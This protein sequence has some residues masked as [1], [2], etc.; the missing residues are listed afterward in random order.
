MKMKF[1]V[2]ENLKSYSLL[3][4]LRNVIRSDT[5]TVKYVYRSFLYHW[6][7]KL[8][9]SR[10]DFNLKRFK[11]DKEQKKFYKRWYYLPKYLNHGMYSSMDDL[12][13]LH[14]SILEERIIL[15][16][17]IDFFYIH[18]NNF[19][20][21]GETLD[22]TPPILRF[23]ETISNSSSFHNSFS[24]LEII[25]EQNEKINYEKNSVSVVFAGLLGWK[26]VS[27]ESFAAKRIFEKGSLVE[28]AQKD[29]YYTIS[30]FK[31][32]LTERKLTKSQ[33]RKR[34]KNKDKEEELE[35]LSSGLPKI[36]SLVR[37]DYRRIKE[38]KLIKYAEYY[39]S[40]C[41]V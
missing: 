27:D 39:L 28:I 40:S 23:H 31:P 14:Q 22:E 6:Y 11:K 17:D 37:T 15:T 41:A 36:E 30:I 10:P 26:K 13:I 2:D 8:R 29:N 38:D 25:G 3:Y 24:G 32:I 4:F 19:I 9:D 33:K 18:L 5:I 34:K 1:F 16:R 35:K 20:L 21:T 12:S 7:R